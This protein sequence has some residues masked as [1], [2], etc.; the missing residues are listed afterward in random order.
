MV[1]TSSSWIHLNS[2]APPGLKLCSSASG[3]GMV[4]AARG[5]CSR[6]CGAM[7]PLLVLLASIPSTLHCSHT[8]AAVVGKMYPRGNHWAVGHLM[9]KKSVESSPEPRRTNPDGDDL[10]PSDRAEVTGRLLEALMQHKSQ[11]QRKPAPAGRLHG[12]WRQEER[13]K[14]LR[15]VSD[16]ILLALKLR[17][18]A[19]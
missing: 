6:R 14:Y 7:W 17:D 11:R 13:D 16:L 2:R 8:P 18:A 19:S 5:R 10:A 9:G 4:R 3:S 15:E 12:G 1:D